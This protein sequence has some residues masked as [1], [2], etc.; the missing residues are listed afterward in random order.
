MSK[1]TINTTNPNGI[2]MNCTID[3][4]DDIVNGIKLLS[5]ESNFK[6]I[7][8]VNQTVANDLIIAIKSAVPVNTGDLKNSIE[9][10]K[11]KKNTNFLWVGPN[12]S[13]KKSMFKGGNHAHLVEYGTVDRYVGSKSKY[14]AANLSKAG[15]KQGFKG[16]MP[17]HPFI[18]PTYDKMKTSLLEKLKKGYE[19]VIVEAAKK[20]GV[21]SEGR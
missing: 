9:S 18:R 15:V 6:D 20:T 17:A 1:L 12:Y 7:E 19:S 4:V 16:K 8:K 11:S 2:S 14:V 21:F 3:G 5:N 10:F 13:T